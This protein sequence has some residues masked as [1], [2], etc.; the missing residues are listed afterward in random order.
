[1][2]GLQVKTTLI[3]GYHQHR[4]VGPVSGR[5]TMAVGLNVCVF[6]LKAFFL[7]VDR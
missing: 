2:I 1:M 7:K 5:N 4:V 3:I 6:D